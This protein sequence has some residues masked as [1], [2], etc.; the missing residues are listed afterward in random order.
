MM[1]LLGDT[2]GMRTQVGGL[3]WCVVGV[4]YLLVDAAHAQDF[5]SFAFFASY[6]DHI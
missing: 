6:S 3:S 2:L 5:V 4:E 1:M